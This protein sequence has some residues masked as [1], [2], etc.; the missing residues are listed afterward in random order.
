MEINNRPSPDC[1]GKIHKNYGDYCRVKCPFTALC[2]LVLMGELLRGNR[3]ADK[4]EIPGQHG[5]QEK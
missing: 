1:L 3:L 2:V 4:K 5:E